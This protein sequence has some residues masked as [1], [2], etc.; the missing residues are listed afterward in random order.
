MR[1][2]PMNALRAFEAAARHGG[3]IAAADE[4][5][6]TRGA[7]SRHVKLLEDHLGVALFHRSARGV[8]L[9]AAGKRLSPVL[10]EAFGTIAREIGE[11]TSAAAE[12]RIICPPALSI[13]WLL[14]KLEDF[15]ARHPDIRVRLTTDFYGDEGFDAS[16]FDLGISIEHRPGRPPDI[17]VQPLFPMLLS[18][19]CAPG[20]LN[21][22]MVL[23]APEDLGACT[24]LHEAASRGDWQIWLR[25]FGVADVD[26]RGGQVFPNFDIA[27]RAAIMGAGVVMADLMLCREEVAQGA[28]V[29]PFPD[30]ICDTPHG[31]IAL[32]GPR[33]KW[34]DTK[35]AAFRTWIAQV[36]GADSA[37]LAAQFGIDPDLGSGVRTAD[38]PA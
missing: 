32:I 27:A 29:L 37:A 17:E 23:N 33:D 16:E 24:L 28:L 3:Y 1:L 19:G 26:P 21:G 14:P 31:R 36:A 30:R 6:V 15:R 7:V 11:M 13:R 4:L 5:C 18:P 2:P 34:H 22:D 10:S 12:L 20:L 35:V 8:A 38:V 9:T 25:R